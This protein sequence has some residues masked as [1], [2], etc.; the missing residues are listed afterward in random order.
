MADEKIYELFD[1]DLMHEAAVEAW[2]SLASTPCASE[3]M[4]QAGIEF[5]GFTYALDNRLIS[6][7]AERGVVDENFPEGAGLDQYKALASVAAEHFEGDLSS[8]WEHDAF[9]SLALRIADEVFP[10]DETETKTN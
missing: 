10:A 8:T 7:L 1:F 2:P 9:H 4:M 3:R 5:Y 6:M